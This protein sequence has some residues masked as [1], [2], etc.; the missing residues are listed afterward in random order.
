ME[1]IEENGIKYNVFSDSVG[2]RW[3][4]RNPNSL[5]SRSP[6]SRINGPAVIRKN[7]IKEYWL[8]GKH[9]PEITSDEEWLLFQII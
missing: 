2:I 1:I 9:Y 7:G 3:R 5:L 8:N 4:L 6:L